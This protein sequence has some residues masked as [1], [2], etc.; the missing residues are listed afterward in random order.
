MFYDYPNTHLI[1]RETG[2]ELKR[3]IGNLADTM[4][5]VNNKV[6]RQHEEDMRALRHL[7]KA[8]RGMFKPRKEESSEQKKETV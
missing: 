2:D 3:S 8:I 7:R 6:M 1:W 4:E 5:D